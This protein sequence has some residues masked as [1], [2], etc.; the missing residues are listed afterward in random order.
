MADEEGEQTGGDTNGG[1]QVGGALAPAIED[2][3]LMPEQHRFGDNGT[4]TPC[5]PGGPW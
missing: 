4:E 3:Q 1:A 5:L 2:Q